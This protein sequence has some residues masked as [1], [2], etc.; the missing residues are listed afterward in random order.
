MRY[1]S[2][3]VNALTTWVQISIFSLFLCSNVF[4]STVAEENSSSSLKFIAPAFEKDLG[5]LGEWKG[6][7]VLSGFGMLQ[8]NPDRT[9]KA[10]LADFSNT[11]IVVEQRK[12]SFSF[13]AQVGYYD[14]LDIG[15]P[16]QRI[17]QQTINSFGVVPQAQI[18]YSIDQNLKISIGKLPALGGYESSFSY[19]NLNVE[20][21]VLW[22]QTSSFSEGIQVDYEHG[23]FS[24]S[25]AFTDGFYSNK[26]NWLGADISYKLTKSQK[27]GLIWTGALSPNAYATDDTP[28]LKNNSQIFNLL[29]NQSVGRWNFSPYIQY[30]YVP[31]NPSIGILQSAETYGAALLT[32]YKFTVDLDG[33]GSNYQKA[34]IPFRVEYIQSTGTPG[35]NSPNLL[36]GPGSSALTLTLSPTIQFQKYFARVEISMIKLYDY[37]Q[38]LGFGNNSQNAGQ[39]RG[40][41]EF[42]ILY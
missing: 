6:N 11:L 16:D 9:N 24:A 14:I 21:G 5:I 18:S 22:S 23:A 31:S 38:Q 32:N 30:T 36:Y 27:I 17:T 41:F 15:Q 29:Y 4:A 13:F 7:I 33:S 12:G 1:C 28:L 10:Q 35:S 25:I 37:S 34:S 20:R 39:Y 26:F 8:T 19:Q 40:I 42:G 2:L 3:L